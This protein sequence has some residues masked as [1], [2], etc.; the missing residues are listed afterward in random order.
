MADQK[1]R[2]NS[3]IL[4]LL[5]TGGMGYYL[6]LSILG[7]SILMGILA[8]IFQYQEGLITSGMRDPFPWGL[9][10][11][12]F[13]FLVG[14]AAAAVVFIIPSYIYHYQPLKGIC[15]I[16][17]LLA[18]SS[19]IMALLFVMVDL[20][21]LDRFWHIIPGIGRLNFPQSLMAWDVLVL[22]GY[23]LLNLIIP[24]YL[25]RCKYQGKSPNTR[26]LMPLI[27]LS[28]GWAVSIHTVT[29]LI[30]SSLSSIPSWH[31][32]V[33]APR[34]LA[35]AFTSGPA[36]LILILILVLQIISQCTRLPVE[37][38]VFHIL[39]DIL[40]VALFFNL[41]MSGIE[42]FLDYYTKSPHLVHR[43]YLL[44]GL[45]GHTAYVMPTWI[46]IIAQVCALV[47]LIFPKLRHDLK[48][49]DFACV[50][51][52]VGVWFEKGIGLIASGFIPSTIGE[53]FEYCPTLP[54][55]VITLAIW[56]IGLLIF[57]LL[58]KIAIPIEV[59]DIRA[60]DQGEKYKTA[61]FINRQ[62]KNEEKCRK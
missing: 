29:A 12:N 20:G 39:A 17:E 9:Y 15:I 48:T 16:G 34:F 53:I 14:M 36:F 44:F 55:I 54:E 45:H 33:L 23:L 57:T 10:I 32:A 28:I 60:D 13:V 26:L 8:Y 7:V 21:R 59:G 5:F 19:I 2:K 30:Y 50:C 3:K 49:L 37:K 62:E 27:Y 38:K 43:Q 4:P 6:W 22:W 58:L 25:L 46:S 52:F 40:T 31:Q 51:A 35:S 42:I 24:G 18:A 56:A 61:S 1:N 47:L 41:F 11:A